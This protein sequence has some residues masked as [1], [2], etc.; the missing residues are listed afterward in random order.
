M[1][2]LNKDVKFVKTVGPAK[3]KLL[4][5][6]KI[7]TLKDLI[8]YFPRGY[9]DR[10]KPKKIIECVD[11]EECLIE[12]IVISN[13]IEIRLKKTKMYKLMIQDE[14]SK[15][16]ITWFNQPYLKN[17]FHVGETCKFFGKVSNKFGNIEMTSPVFDKGEISNNT[18]R[19]IPI[20]PL[21]Y[22]LSQNNLRKVIENGIKEVD[23]ELLETLPIDIIKKYNLIGINQAMR[24]IHFPRDFE[25]F[26]K[27]RNRLVFEELFSMQLALLTLKNSYKN[28]SK[29]IQF[30]KE[31][32]MLDVINNLP[33][34]L[35]NA[36]RR[37]LEEIDKDMEK[38]ISM[39]RLLQGD[40]GSGKTI[41]AL[42]AAYKAVKS[43]LSS[44]NNGSYCNSC[45]STFRI[46]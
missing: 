6:I 38:N 27:A 9:E 18:G 5:K 46:I 37:V 34:Q 12:G 33:F 13:V 45:S 23:G 3:V 26:N 20:Y 25:E 35:T 1:V 32:K 43:R 16:S 28:P 24:A 7:N 15:C 31:V 22:E 14:T 42:I 11:G 30:N 39:N 36:Q 8:T 44:C 29:G 17:A 19:I 40:V 2:D 21:T 41:V 4:N 10:N